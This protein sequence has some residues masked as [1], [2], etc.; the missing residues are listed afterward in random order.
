MFPTTTFQGPTTT[1]GLI[2]FSSLCSST[3]SF[4]RSSLLGS[5]HWFLS[6]LQQCLRSRRLRLTSLWLWSRFGSLWKIGLARYHQRRGIWRSS[7][8]TLRRWPHFAENWQ[9]HLHS[10]S[11]GATHEHI[12]NWMYLQFSYTCQPLMSWCVCE[13]F[14]RIEHACN[15]PLDIP[16]QSLLLACWVYMYVQHIQIA[17]PLLWWCSTVGGFLATPN[18]APRLDLLLLHTDLTR[19]YVAICPNCKIPAKK[20][21]MAIQNHHVEV[22]KVFS[23]SASIGANAEKWG[24]IFR[25]AFTKFR[26]LAASKKKMKIVEGQAHTSRYIMEASIHFQEICMCANLYVYKKMVQACWPDSKIL[27]NH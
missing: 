23:N 25:T 22:E 11:D 7:G 17:E 20:F 27:S 5:W 9:G 19:R 14:L 18:T 3:R 13:I 24:G 21:E 15:C 1:Q 8:G 12:Q 10:F 16:C 2:H 4:G 6:L 26:D